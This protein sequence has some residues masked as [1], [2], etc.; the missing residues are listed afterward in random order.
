MNNARGLTQPILLMVRFFCV[1]ISVKNRNQEINMFLNWRIELKGEA[2]EK[3]LRSSRHS[4]VIVLL[5]FYSKYQ[6]KTLFLVSFNKV[7]LR[8]EIWW[9]SSKGVLA[10]TDAD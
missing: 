4:R 2:G 7:L 3:E 6:S 10:A 8:K 5:C 1:E 9:Y